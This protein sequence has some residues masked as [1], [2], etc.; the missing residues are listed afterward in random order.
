MTQKIKVLHYIPGFKFGGIESRMLDVVKKID[1]DRFQLDFLILTDIDNPLIDEF[2]KFGVNIYSIPGFSPQTIFKHFKYIKKILD[3]NK[4]DII[5]SHST[6]NSLILMKYAQYKKIKGRILH[7]RT[8][9][10]TG[11]SKIHL[12]KI[13]QKLTVKSANYFLAVSNIAGKWAFREKKFSI[14]PN[15]INLSDFEYNK[16]SRKIIRERYGIS[17]EIIIG[18]VGRHAYAKNHAFLFEVFKDI[19]SIEPNSKL[20][21]VGVSEFEEEL[22]KYAKEL[23]IREKI[24]FCGYQQDVSKYYSAMDIFIFPS[25]YEG[26]PGTLIEAQTSGLKV[27]CSDTITNEVNLTSNIY[28]LSL[29]NGSAYWANEIMSDVSSLNNRRDYIDDIRSHG[30]TIE[31]TV[32]K[33]E[34]L[35]INLN[36]S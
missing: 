25:F 31:N 19:L 9:S 2:K 15:S 1:R 11:S 34:E 23:N 6:T 26:M 16:E 14:I 27:Y 13:F 35:Y 10:F 7:S 36:N 22:I 3:K 8:S 28:F 17:K 5:H 29:G 12:R 24:I 20:M 4:Y 32:K 18:H 33:F 21:L 30:Y